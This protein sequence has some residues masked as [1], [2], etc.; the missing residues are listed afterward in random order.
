MNLWHACTVL[1]EHRGDAHWAMTAAAGLDAVT[2]HVLHAADGAMPA[3]LL[4]QVSGW[5]DEAWAAGVERLVARGLVAIGDHGPEATTA[6]RQVKW[7][8]EAATDREAARAL[9]VV[10]PDEVRTLID[11]MRPWVRGIIDAEVVGAWKLRE[12][13]WRDLGDRPS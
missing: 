11:I 8:V 5:D 10:S 3:E 1:R 2:C 12:Q 6:G 9:D 4:Q 7:D 13:L